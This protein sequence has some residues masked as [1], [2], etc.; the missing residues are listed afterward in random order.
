MIEVHVKRVLIFVLSMASA[1]GGIIS[2]CK[3]EEDGEQRREE[4][5]VGAG[6][7]RARGG[8]REPAVLLDLF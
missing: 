2:W 6:C 7:G 8:R 5:S 3:K 4:K 1:A